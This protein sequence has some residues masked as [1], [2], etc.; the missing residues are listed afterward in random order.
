MSMRHTTSRFSSQPHVY[1]LLVFQV[2]NMAADMGGMGFIESNQV[3]RVAD[4]KGNLSG[5]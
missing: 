3:S 1:D 5:F 2:Y 4:G